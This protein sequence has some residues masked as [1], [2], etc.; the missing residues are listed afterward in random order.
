[1]Q[2]IH[3]MQINLWNSLRSK[4]EKDYTKEFA[5]VYPSIEGSNM[6]IGNYVTINQLY[7][8]YIFGQDVVHIQKNEEGLSYQV[9]MVRKIMISLDDISIGN[10]KYMWSMFKALQFQDA[11][12]LIFVFYPRKNDDVEFVRTNFIKTLY[13]IPQPITKEIEKKIKLDFID[14]RNLSPIEMGGN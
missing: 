1:M 5:F 7:S 3:L 12:E 13:Q 9:P 2:M 8:K 11:K 4:I 10:F 6:A 14:N